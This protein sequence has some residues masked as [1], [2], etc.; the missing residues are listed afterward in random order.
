[1]DINGS[2]RLSGTYPSITFTE[3]ASGRTAYLASTDG[4]NMYL[5]QGNSGAL[6]LSGSAVYL[7]APSGIGTSVINIPT[8]NALAIWGGNVF[9]NNGITALGTGV[10]PGTVSTPAMLLTN[11]SEQV[12]VNAAATWGGNITVN[13][14]NASVVYYTAP[15]TA[16]WNVNITHSSTSTLGSVLGVG[17]AVSI[18]FV[19][20]MGTTAY[21]NGNITVDGSNSGVTVGWQGNAAPTSG[22]VSC[23][24]VYNYTVIKTAATPTYTVLAGQAQY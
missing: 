17:Q 8:G 5:N 3:T 24:D 14:S 20:T 16:N 9:V 22:H 10:F 12:Q 18:A 1:L 15:A 23:I 2:L 21:W 13:L 7:S 19:A 4:Y 11:I 6:S